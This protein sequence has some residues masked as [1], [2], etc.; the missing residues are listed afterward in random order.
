V[1]DAAIEEG[2]IDANHLV[3]AYALSLNYKEIH[4]Y[5]LIDCRAMG[6][7]FIDQD[8]TNHHQLLP[9]PLETP[10]ALEVIDG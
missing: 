2:S 8:F 7:A 6:Y 9:C 1:E 4:T 10:H 5:A 3:M